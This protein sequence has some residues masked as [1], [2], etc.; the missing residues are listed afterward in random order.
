MLYQ[1]KKG[2]C[3]KKRLIGCYR[4]SLSPFIFTLEWYGHELLSVNTQVEKEG[5]KTAKEFRNPTSKCLSSS[6]EAWNLRNNDEAKI[7]E[8][9]YQVYKCRFYTIAFQKKMTIFPASSL[10]LLGVQNLSQQKKKY[11]KARDN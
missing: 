8:S 9:R 3:I 11:N 1:F 4:E 10:S 6:L 2:K 5:R 7:E